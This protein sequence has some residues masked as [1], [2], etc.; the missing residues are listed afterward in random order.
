M[1][2]EKKN[3]ILYC[4]SFLLTLGICFVTFALWFAFINYQR[5]ELF[6]IFPPVLFLVFLIGGFTIAYL[7]I[8]GSNNKIEKWAGASSKHW[9]SILIMLIA[10]PVY[11]VLLSLHERKNNA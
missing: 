10:Y 6:S 2:K 11:L 5:Q 9:I 8:Y 7:G 4:R 1:G 3:W